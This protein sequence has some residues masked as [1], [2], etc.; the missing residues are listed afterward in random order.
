MF[1][2]LENGTIVGHI[3]CSNAVVKKD[4]QT[5]LVLNFGPLSVLPE[6]QHQGVGKALVRALVERAKKLDYSAIIFFG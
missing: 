3:I 2:F 5:L 1:L 6:Y 4:N